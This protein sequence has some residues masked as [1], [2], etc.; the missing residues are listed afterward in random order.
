MALP[1]SG[2]TISLSQ[3]N[4]ELGRSATQTIDMND[5][6]LRT[7]FSKTGYGNTISMSDGWGRSNVSFSSLGSQLDGTNPYTGSNVSFELD[8]NRFAEYPKLKF[9]HF[10]DFFQNLH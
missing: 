8:F 7:L 2:S 3:V 1:G 10:Q 9:L 5:S 6:S 4:T